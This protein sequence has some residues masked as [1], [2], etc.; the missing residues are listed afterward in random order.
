VVMKSSFFWDITPCSP[1]K[2]LA[3]CSSETST[4]F[5]RTTCRYIP[6]DKTLHD[7]NNMCISENFLCEYVRNGIMYVSRLLLL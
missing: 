3:T 2:L 6:E 7:N 5:Q 1:S 4:D